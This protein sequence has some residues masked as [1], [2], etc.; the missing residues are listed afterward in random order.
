MESECSASP[1]VNVDVHER[2]RA[3]AAGEPLGL[4]MVS[5]PKPKAKE[6]EVLT[7]VSALMLAVAC[8]GL[9]AGQR[10]HGHQTTWSTVCFCGSA[11]CFMTTAMMSSAILMI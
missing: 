9:F 3:F 1:D 5:Y 6:L 2:V 4:W 11:F 10:L 8:S 7:L